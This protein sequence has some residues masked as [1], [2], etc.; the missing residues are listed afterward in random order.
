MYG[1]LK[2]SL[3]RTVVVQGERHQI[4]QWRLSIRIE[5][6]RLA[7]EP[8]HFFGGGGRDGGEGG[9]EIKAGKNGGGRER[10]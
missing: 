6:T 2:W 10:K 9:R 4:H 8:A 3:G 5:D 1:T 7:C